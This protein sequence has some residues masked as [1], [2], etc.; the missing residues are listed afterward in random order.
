MEEEESPT[1]KAGTP[2]ST[3]LGRAYRANPSLLYAALPVQQQDVNQNTDDANLR[4]AGR[5]DDDAKD[6]WR[7]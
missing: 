6:F 7:A 2:S 3:H 4:Q 5:E 1:P